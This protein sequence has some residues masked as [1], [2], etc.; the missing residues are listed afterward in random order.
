MR[1]HACVC[2]W[3]ERQVTGGLHGRDRLGGNSL[4]E[5]LVFGRAV[6]ESMPI[7]MRDTAAAAAAAE[8]GVHARARARLRLNVRVCV[9]ICACAFA[10][11]RVRAYLPVSVAVYVCECTPTS[12]PCSGI[13]RRCTHTHMHTRTHLRPLPTQTPTP[14]LSLARSLSLSLTHTHTQTTHTTATFITAV[15]GRAARRRARAG[16]HRGRGDR[17]AALHARRR[18][19]ARL[20]PKLLDDPAQQGTRGFWKVLHCEVHIMHATRDSLRR[21]PRTPRGIRTHTSG[22]TA[23]TREVRAMHA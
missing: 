19:Q 23:R 5:C 4:T 16:G 15:A 9:C 3:R 11:V 6:G 7:A 18:R 1:A 8:V 22:Y 21:K 14:T 17:G 20:S 12:L 13:L 2:V 10:F